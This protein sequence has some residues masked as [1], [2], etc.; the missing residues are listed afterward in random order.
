MNT[1][2]TDFSYL[3]GPGPTPQRDFLTSVM[4]HGEKIMPSDTFDI[5][6]DRYTLLDITQ[7]EGEIITLHI[8]GLK[9]PNLGHKY[10]ILLSRFEEMSADDLNQFFNQS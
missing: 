5:G 10:E 9:G 7:T 4:I 8:L 1:T 2:N 6:S 3:G